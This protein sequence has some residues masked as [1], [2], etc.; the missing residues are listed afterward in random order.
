MK[1]VKPYEQA[2]FAMTCRSYP[3]YEAMFSFKERPL[4]SGPVL[5][6]AGGASSFVAEACGQGLDAVAVDPLYGQTPEKIDANGLQEI[7]ISA[8]KL[9]AL[10]EQFDWTYYGSVE[11]STEMRIRSLRAF[12]EHY[13][14]QP[15]RYI[16]ASLPSLPFQDE[17]FETVLCSHFLFLYGNA[18]LSESF[19]LE[20]LEELLRVTRPGGEIRIYPLVTLAFKP[21]SGLETLEQQLQKKA[22]FIRENSQLPFIPGSKTY[23][24]IRKFDR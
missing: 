14:K 18:A 2:G 15:E 22:C 8:G 10:Q 7:E 21:Y 24:M 23:V 9:A 5:D 17:A 16:Q 20:A 12:S 4:G 19:H 11:K 1:E 3:E 13:A 6:V